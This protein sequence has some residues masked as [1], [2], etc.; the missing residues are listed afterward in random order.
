MS[1]WGTDALSKYQGP[2]IVVRLRKDG[3]HFTETWNKDSLLGNQTDSL[4]AETNPK[5]CFD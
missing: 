2:P 5:F 3:S 1:L 4:G